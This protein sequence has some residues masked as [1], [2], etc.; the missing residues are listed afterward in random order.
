MTYYIYDTLNKERLDK[1]Y[2][3]RQRV[4]RVADKLNYNYGCVRYAVRVVNK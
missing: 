3:N 2:T 1:T 4:S